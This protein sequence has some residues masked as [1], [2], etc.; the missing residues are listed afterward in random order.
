MQVYSQTQLQ[1]LPS[2][3]NK[4]RLTDDS[5]PL[6]TAA[7]KA[8]TDHARTA[9]SNKRKH[10]NG[11]ELPGGMRIVRAVEPVS[12][13]TSAQ[14]NTSTSS[15][16]ASQPP[17]RPP[18]RS[19]PNPLSSHPVKKFKADSQPPSQPSASRL[20]SSQPD[21]QAA[22]RSWP[23][24]SSATPQEEESVV[25]ERDIRAMEDE[26]DRLRRESRARRL[27][28][29]LL[30]SSSPI[31]PSSQP[32]MMNGN[33]RRSISVTRDSR[34]VVPVDES[35]I[36]TK[37]KKL[38]EG[39]MTSIR[40][41]QEEAE[42]RGRPR[43]SGSGSGNGHRR[44]SSINSRGKRISSSFE[45]GHIPQPHKHVSESSFYKH[46]DA[47]LPQSE[48][49]TRLLI[50]CSH[51]AAQ[52][53]D[54]SSSSYVTHPDLPPLTTQEV[55]TLKKA[56]EDVIRLLAEKKI[57]LM[58]S[59]TP[60]RQSSR[61][62]PPK[63]N[64]QNASNRRYEATYTDQ[65][66]KMEDENRTWARVEDFYDSYVKKEKESMTK[67]KETIERMKNSTYP[68]QSAKAKGK[69]KASE[70]DQEEDWNWLPSEAHVSDSSR[71]LI[72]LS[73]SVLGIRTGGSSEREQ[74]EKLL[75]QRMDDL[76]FNLD[77]LQ[78]YVNVGRAATNVAEVLLDERYK[79]LSDA[80][81]A[82]SGIAPPSFLDTGGPSASATR[83][84][85]DYMPRDAGGR[86][87]DKPSPHSLLK[88]LAR[89][90]SER[91]PTKIGDA[92][93]RAARE[94]QRM[95]QEGVTT[96]VSERRLTGV[97]PLPGTPRKMPGTPRRGSTPGRDRSTPGR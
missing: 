12:R 32:S 89:V 88:A 83:L 59:A 10:D 86:P 67:R 53:F 92:A 65:I 82:R 34:Q 84:L 9:A 4:R 45:L 69:Q 97:P 42:E 94:V 85:A 28:P 23:K 66:R 37:N 70:E 6:L 49:L 87:R 90:D 29:S 61:V 54:P 24:G 93:R 60:P 91:P 17:E 64:E 11:E 75:Q 40:E 1:M 51:R 26:A 44:R 58:S 22:S 38:R 96:G 31:H 25:I 68:S 74:S 79:V 27:N 13:P 71:S 8:K 14:G 5:N 78:E 41:D 33:S 63:E 3:S 43:A 73:K 7:K 18:S 57:D 50:W 15:R 39:A 21:P 77:Q 19:Q 36:I 48:R 46:I 76:E 2:Q 55:E 56:Q 47:D 81:H 62:P 20:P 72:A 35:P 52:A 80:L 95:E 16:P 30:Q